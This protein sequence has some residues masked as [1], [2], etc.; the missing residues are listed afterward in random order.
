MRQMK[1]GRISGDTVVKCGVTEKLG[2]E[3]KES[4]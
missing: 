1:M 2:D 4:L 3:R